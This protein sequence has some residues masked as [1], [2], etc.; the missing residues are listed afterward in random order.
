[1][2]KADKSPIKSMTF[3]ERLWHVILAVLLLI[4]GAYGL[5]TDDLYI[6]GKRSRGVH[7]HGMAA[8][9][10]Y[11]AF[12]LA[13]INLISVAVD[14]C[15]TS[16]HGRNYPVLARVTQVAGWSLFAAALLV[17]LWHRNQ[18]GW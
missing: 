3:S 6:P 17:G 16:E 12:V 1:M 10:M 7:L 18:P 11:G 14:H 9:I 5:N 13:A 2:E 15:D 8:W 4:Y